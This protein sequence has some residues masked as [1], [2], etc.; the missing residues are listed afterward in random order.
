MVSGEWCFMSVQLPA[1]LPPH[2]P[3]WASHQPSGVNRIHQLVIINLANG[4]PC[5]AE[6]SRDEQY[7]LSE[8]SILASLSWSKTGS[9]HLIFLSNGP[10]QFNFLHFTNV[11]GDW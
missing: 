8:S 2:S 5:S 6:Q 9:F 10:V 11:S 1:G 3:H 7:S 4:E